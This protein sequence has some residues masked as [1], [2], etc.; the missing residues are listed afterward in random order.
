[1]HF[2]TEVCDLIQYRSVMFRSSTFLTRYHLFSSADFKMYS[3]YAVAV[4]DLDRTL[5]IDGCCSDI[6]RETNKTHIGILPTS[7]VTV[8]VR[9]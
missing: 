2:E 6:K 8:P 5:A 9:I 4:S 1:M 7:I 3:P